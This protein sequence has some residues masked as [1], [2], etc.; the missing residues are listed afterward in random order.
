MSLFKNNI[1]IFFCNFLQK[2]RRKKHLLKTKTLVLCLRL[3]KY[4]RKGVIFKKCHCKPTSTASTA[5]F[6]WLLK[7]HSCHLIAL[8]TACSD[9]NLEKESFKLGLLPT[10]GQKMLKKIYHLLKWMH[11]RVLILKFQAFFSQKNKNFTSSKH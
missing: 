2:I 10:W 6:T 4:G 9:A 7:G 3:A 8:H 5:D 11:I 1:S